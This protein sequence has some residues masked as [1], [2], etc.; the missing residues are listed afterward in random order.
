ML[1]ENSRFKKHVNSFS[2]KYKASAYYFNALSN[3]LAKDFKSALHNCNQ[4]I[5]NLDN[6]L[7]EF[8]YARLLRIFI[9]V[10]QENYFTIDFECRSL[11]RLM[12][13]EVLSRQNELR[14]LKAIQ[15]SP[16]FSSKDWKQFLA[17]SKS[18]F[19]K[20][21]TLTYYLSG[22]LNLKY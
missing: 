18:E 5:N 19:T 1:K 13:K 7:E 8:L 2:L 12:Q 16:D 4:L 6:G 17:K 9:Y 22:V 15:K 14:I 21:K 11:T 20:D 10:N 3:Y